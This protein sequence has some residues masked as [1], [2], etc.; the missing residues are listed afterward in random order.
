MLTR[1]SLF[2]RF[3]KNRRKIFFTQ[4]VIEM[5]RWSIFFVKCHRMRT[6]CWS[7]VLY[8]YFCLWKEYSGWKCS[9]FSRKFS[10]S[11]K[12][13]TSGNSYFPIISFSYSIEHC[14]EIIYL[15]FLLID[16]NSTRCTVFFFF[17]Y[18][19][20]PFLPAS[21]HVIKWKEWEWKRWTFFDLRTF[22]YDSLFHRLVY[23]SKIVLIQFFPALSCLLFNQFSTTRTYFFVA[24]F[25]IAFETSYKGV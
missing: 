21:L 3:S 16:C 7:H 23:Y 22:I 11:N 13:I 19:F 14:S 18:I 8:Y 25:A 10:I 2:K 6:K 12:S 20:S 24:R 15:K 17:V 5:N 9:R 4:S 1:F